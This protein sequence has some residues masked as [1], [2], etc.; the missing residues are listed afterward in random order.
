MPE[1]EVRFLLKAC[2]MPPTKHPSS[3]RSDNTRDPAHGRLMPNI[4]PRAWETAGILL[5]DTDLKA[6]SI[7]IADKADITSKTDRIRAL[8][9]SKAGS[10]LKPLHPISQGP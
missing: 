10:R 1:D 4:G 2:D 3:V 6:L 9:R 8:P 7:H 5:D